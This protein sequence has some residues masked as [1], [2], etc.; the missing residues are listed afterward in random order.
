[1]SAN[2]KTVHQHPLLTFVVISVD[3]NIRQQ[4]VQN[5]P[6]AVHHAGDDGGRD[7]GAEGHPADLLHEALWGGDKQRIKQIGVHFTTE[8]L[9][10]HHDITW[11]MRENQV[12]FESSTNTI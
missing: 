11:Y 6:A 3:V 2:H 4:V 1:M 7:L 10:K 8:I 12:Y 5:S 9:N